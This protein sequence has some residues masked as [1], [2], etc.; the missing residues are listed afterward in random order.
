VSAAGDLAA[1]EHELDEL[2]TLWLQA[3]I[4]T[5]RQGRSDDALVDEGR[6]V[7]ERLRDG[8]LRDVDPGDPGGATAHAW[9][10]IRTPR[11][12]KAVRRELRRELARVAVKRGRPV[13]AAEHE[14]D[15]HNEVSERLGAISYMKAV[16]GKVVRDLEAEQQA[17]ALQPRRPEHRRFW[18]R[19]PG[20]RRFSRAPLRV[21][22]RG[23]RSRR[24]TLRRSPARSPGRSEPE[25]SRP[26]GAAA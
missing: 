7:F 17:R 8:Y 22:V 13:T 20:T 15:Q 1:P 26:L 6:R 16:N 9:Q 4:R 10:A 5:G 2:H 25:P 11:I 23:R 24:Q 3:M 14:A 18:A 21:R 12:V 19:A